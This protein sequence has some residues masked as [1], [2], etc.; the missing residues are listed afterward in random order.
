MKVLASALLAAAVPVLGSIGETGFC[1]SIDSIQSHLARRIIGRTVE[2]YDGDKLGKL[3]DFAVEM[4]SGQVACAIISS[5][6][7]AGIGSTWKP[8]PPQSLS[9]ATA[10]RGTAALL[11]RGFR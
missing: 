6:G 4:R 7:V 1:Q 3:K 5:G 2:N 10:K 9:L 8:V 11:A